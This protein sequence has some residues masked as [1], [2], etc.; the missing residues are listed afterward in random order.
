MSTRIDSAESVWQISDK[1]GWLRKCQN[2]KIMMDHQN[3]HYRALCPGRHPL[4]RTNTPW[5]DQLNSLLL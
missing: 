4:H 1:A 2:R 3:R 5:Q